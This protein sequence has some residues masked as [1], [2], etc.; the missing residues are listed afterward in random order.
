MKIKAYFFLLVLLISHSIVGQKGQFT[1]TLLSENEKVIAFARIEIVEA[2]KSFY[3]DNKG[4]FLS[5][6]IPYGSYTIKI[7]SEGFLPLEQASNLAAPELEV[8]FDFQRN[9]TYSFEEI[10][11]TRKKSNSF[12]NS[13]STAMFSAQPGIEGSFRPLTRSR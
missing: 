9:N 8:S 10:A 7:V 13:S 11:V 6:K 1:G 4:F 12:F 2:E 3:S 5:P